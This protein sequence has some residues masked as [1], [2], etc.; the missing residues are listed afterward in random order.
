MLNSNIFSIQTASLNDLS[1]IME[2]ERAG[3]IHQIQET[4][5]IFEK[6][7]LLCPQLFLLIKHDLTNKIIGY[8]S[9]E[10]MEKIPE[11]AEDIRL[12]HIP[13]SVPSC[14]NFNYIYIS[15]FSI[16]PTFRG[17]GNGKIIWNQCMKYLS[18]MTLS[19]NDKTSLSLV[20]QKKILI[21]LVNQD[22][23]GAKHIYEQNGFHTQNIF[24]DFFPRQDG[25]FS[26]GVLMIK[27]L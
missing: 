13:V 16:L 23:Q 10:P 2:I 15:S 12:N 14:K 11:K 1:K 6:R 5:D 20:V 24:K 19:P 21:L 9:A 25:S 27:E 8:L 3:F 26:D 17:K 22:W 4:E 7:I 18:Q